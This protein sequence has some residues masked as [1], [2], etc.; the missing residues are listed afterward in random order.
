MHSSSL[1]TPDPTTFMGGRILPSPFDVGSGHLTGFSQRDVY[2]HDMRRSFNRHVQLGLNFAFIPLYEN[3]GSHWFL[4]GK[5]CEIDLVQP[6]SGAN[7]DPA[8]SHLD[9]H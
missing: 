9:Q 6:S 4:A 8:K 7:F 1:L 5:T 2:R 3:L